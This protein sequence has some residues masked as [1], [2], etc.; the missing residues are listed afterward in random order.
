MATMVSRTYCREILWEHRL[1][2]A[3]EGVP[4]TYQVGGR[5]Y[6]TV[7]VGGTGLFAGGLGLPEPGPSRYVTFALPR[8]YRADDSQMP[9][10]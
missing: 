10:R 5:Q 3:T 4:A 1:D 9:V 7:P 2:A 8:D 6:I